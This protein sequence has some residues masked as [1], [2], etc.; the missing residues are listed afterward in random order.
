[1]CGPTE[2]QTKLQDSQAAFYD[3][4]QKQDAVQFGEDQQILTQM[5]SVYAPILAAGANQYGFSPEED[6]ILNTEATEGVAGNFAGASK[7]LKEEMAAE[8]GGNAYLPSGVKAQ[9]LETLDSAAAQTAANEKLQIKQ[10]GFAQGYDKFKTATGALEGTA[11]LLNPSAAASVANTAG[12]DESS[13]AAAIAAENES[14]MAPLAGAA[15]AV[16]AAALTHKP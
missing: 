1:M 8:G 2:A 3:T 15:G 5:Q 6:Q 7:A 14:W 10:A 13:T 16:G 4:L 9:Q 12:S 11:G